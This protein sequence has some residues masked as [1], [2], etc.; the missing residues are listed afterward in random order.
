[1]CCCGS[2]LC[3]IMSSASRTSDTFRIAELCAPILF[4]G[5]S[6]AVLE[7]LPAVPVLVRSSDSGV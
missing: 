7:T 2:L 5:K 4:Q 6:A 1:M 3:S